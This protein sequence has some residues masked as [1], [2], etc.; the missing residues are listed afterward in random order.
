MDS[1]NALPTNSNTFLN[2]NCRQKLNWTKFDQFNMIYWNINS[3]RNKLF[4][5]E[6]IAYQNSAKTT[7][8]IALTE[9]QILDNETDFFNIPNYNSYFSNR[10]DGH[11]G[12]ALFV[13][14]SLDSNLVASGVEY[15]VDI[16]SNKLCHCKYSDCENK[17]CRC[18]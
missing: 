8:F 4:D 17:H 2:I 9:T 3:I 12:A 15:K 6:E 14:D 5:I 7:H 11:G 16:P 1:P 18:L 13:H 10:D